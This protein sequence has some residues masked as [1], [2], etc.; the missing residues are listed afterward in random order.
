VWTHR[1]QARF[2]EA[3][4]GPG[5]RATPAVD[6]GRLFTLGA[7]GILDALD[8]SGGALLWSRN[9]VSDSGSKVPTWGFS[10][11]PLVVD[12]LVIVAAGGALIAYEVATGDL[13]WRGPDGGPSYSSPQR[14]VI[15]GVEQIVFLSHAGVTSFAAGDGQRLWKHSWPGASLVQPAL[16]AS[17]DVLISAGE[18]KGVR[19]IEVLHEADGW[20]IEERWESNYLKPN[21]NDFV[22][23]EGHAYGFDGRILACIDLEDGARQW[24]GGRF[25]HG[26]LVL[27]PDQDLLL[28]LSERGELALVAATPRQFEELARVPAIKG[29]TWNHPVVVEDL[30][31][32]RNGREMGAFR[33]PRASG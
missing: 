6:E 2:F 17:G 4:G 21:F 12:D 15:A 11:S 25:G 23:H 14:L 1:N 32:V 18:G 33:L 7:T 31:L 19:R 20:R 3:M 24:K 5:P 8:A 9:V 26:Q 28:V 29:K 13:R 27:L 16:T 10:S 22:V 30:L